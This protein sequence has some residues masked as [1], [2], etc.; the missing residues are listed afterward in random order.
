MESAR[1]CV[2]V[3]T[4]ASADGVDFQVAPEESSF[5]FV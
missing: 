3:C 5:G 1:V 4:C 2:G